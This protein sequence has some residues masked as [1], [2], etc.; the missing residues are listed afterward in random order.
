M[1]NA[2]KI[3]FYKNGPQYRTKLKQ[4]DRFGD[5]NRVNSSN[6]NATILKFSEKF[7]HPFSHV[8]IFG[9][10]LL[11][12]H[13]FVTMPVPSCVKDTCSNL[14]LSYLKQFETIL[15]PQDM[16]QDI[17]KLHWNIIHKSSGV[18]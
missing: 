9:S 12:S 11:E 16:I 17:Y 18:T 6:F 8:F 2:P 1:D 4:I 5:Y 15:F 3:A 7:D 14:S 10:M 13:G